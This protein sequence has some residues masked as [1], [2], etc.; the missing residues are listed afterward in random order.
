MGSRAVL[1]QG[2]QCRLR[3]HQCEGG[4]DRDQTGLSRS[5]PAPPLPRAGR[6]PLFLT[7]PTRAL[8]GQQVICSEGNGVNRD[9]SSDGSAASSPSQTAQVSGLRTLG[10][11]ELPDDLVRGLL[12]KQ[13]LLV[14]VDALSERESDTQ[15]HVV[16]VFGEEVSFSAIVI[17]SRA[18]PVLGAVDRTTLYPVR[19]DAARV[20]PFIIGY[21]DRLKHA[22]S[23]KGWSRPI[24]AGRTDPG[25]GRGRRAGASD[26]G[27]AAARDALRTERDRSGGGGEIARC[28]SS[29]R[30]FADTGRNRSNG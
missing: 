20:V 23:L 10:D 7:F 1:G 29:K 13:R 8:T 16:Q 5:V 18:E 4:R 14:I 11:E 26:T 21:L 17:T 28:G 3:E 9:L 12:A 19:L 24:T 2:H 30:C 6:Q 15:Q 25:L 22:E 27:D